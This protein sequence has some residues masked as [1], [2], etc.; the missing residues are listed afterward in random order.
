MK[1]FVE[2]AN[3][4]KFSKLDDIGTA[5][6]RRFELFFVDALFDLIAGYTKLYSHEEK[7]DTTCEITNK[8]FH[9]FL[10]MVLLSGC[11]KLPD[12]KMY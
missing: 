12:R 6:L 4:P 10:G 2:Q 8:T 9:L 1:N 5:P 7:A 11:N 3:I